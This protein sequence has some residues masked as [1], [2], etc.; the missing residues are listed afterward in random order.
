MTDRQSDFLDGRIF[1]RL[2]SKIFPNRFLTDCQKKALSELFWA[3]FWEILGQILA[4]S[5][6][7]W[8]MFGHNS[9]FFLADWRM[10]FFVRTV[11]SDCLADKFGGQLEISTISHCFTARAVGAYARTFH[12]CNLQQLLVFKALRVRP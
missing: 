8:A 5:G 4:I 11:Y 12:G 10:V 3:L 9:V 2:V 1:G 7:F 6:I